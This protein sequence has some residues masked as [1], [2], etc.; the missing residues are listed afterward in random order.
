MS[1]ATQ[2]TRLQNAKAAIKTAIEAKGVSVIST[3]KL[4]DYATHISAIQQESI[5][6]SGN[7]YVSGE[8]K[9]D[10]EYAWVGIGA[11]WSTVAAKASA[12]DGLKA[13]TYSDKIYCIGGE[14]TPTGNFCYNPTTNTWTTK[15]V[16]T[17][18]RRF[19][20]VEAV[21]NYIYAVGGRSTANQATSYNEQYNPATNTWTTKTAT[22][23]TCEFRGSAEHN[24]LLY[25]VGGINYCY[26]PATN[27]W[28]TKISGG[29]GG[30]EAVTY[31][32]KIYCI[33]GGTGNFCYNPTT[34]TWET[35]TSMSTSRSYFGLEI[36]NG[37][38]YAI[39]GWNGSSNLST[40][41]VYDTSTNTWTFIEDIITA[42]RHFGCTTVGNSIFCVGGYTSSPTDVNEKLTIEWG[43]MNIEFMQGLEIIEAT[44]LNLIVGDDI[45]DSLPYPTNPD[46][47]FRL[48]L[49]V[50]LNW[51]TSIK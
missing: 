28:T 30:A 50:P 9:N 49:K 15:S 29:A 19:L 41:E 42:R 39:S 26:N 47:P 25:I 14:Q 31:N 46:L 11:P 48:K 38:I 33:G 20:I 3:E 40:V 17:Y 23:S 13:S 34:N 8:N 12:E 16:M 37:K 27:T 7:I 5:I 21:G 18:P 6:D 1:V 10:G 24:G 22:P 44:N 36:I 35:K 51:N 43:H 32:D 4:D 45:V 2:I